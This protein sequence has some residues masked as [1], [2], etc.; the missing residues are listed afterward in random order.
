MLATAG[1]VLSPHLERDL[2]IGKLP[3]LAEG[4]DVAAREQPAAQQQPQKEAR[5]VT[6]GVAAVS[7]QGCLKLMHGPL[8]P[9]C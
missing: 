2:L 6:P 4:T 7:L 8:Y 3:L 1:H 9:H 5:K